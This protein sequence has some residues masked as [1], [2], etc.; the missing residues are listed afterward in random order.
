MIKQKLLICVVFLSYLTRILPYTIWQSAACFWF[1]CTS[2]TCNYKCSLRWNISLVCLLQLTRSRL[3]LTTRPM[4]KSWYFT[5]SI[6]SFIHINRKWCNRQLRVHEIWI[7]A[8]N[9]NRQK[10]YV[11]KPDQITYWVFLF[12]SFKCKPSFASVLPRGKELKRPL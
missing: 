8:S 3:S 5:I 7:C 6:L 1:M 10:N 11:N 12:P 2:L 4:Y 9:F